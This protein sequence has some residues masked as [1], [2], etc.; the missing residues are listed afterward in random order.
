GIFRP[1]LA[2]VTHPTSDLINSFY[3]CSDRCWLSL[4]DGPVRGDAALEIAPQR[5]QQ[6]ARQ[7]HHGDAADAALGGADTVAVPDAQCAVGL[8]TQP[9]PGELHHGGAPLTV[10]GLADAL[11]ARCAP[12]L[13]R[14]RREAQ[15]TAELAAIVEFPIEHFADQH[16]GEFGADRPELVQS[17]DLL[18]VEMRRCLVAD[19]SV[20]FRLNGADHLQHDFE[21]LQFPPDLRFQP[22]RQLL[23]LHR[24]QLL[25]PPQ[26][27]RAQRLIVVDPRDRKKP[28]DAV[29]VL[30]ALLR[31][32]I[33]LAV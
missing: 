31:Q 32:P 23:A 22:R 29:G 5:H 6:L 16:G 14:A 4:E 26:P 24:A 15:I 18:R 25:Q 9:Q 27:L 1:A 20:A 8:V 11:L 7:R 12:A 17:L 2:P 19:D 21:A 33:P 3:R 13:E 28:F 30:N 10:A